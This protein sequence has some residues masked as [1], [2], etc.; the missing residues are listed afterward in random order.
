MMADFGFVGSSYTAP[1]IYQDDQE[2]INFYPEVDPIK[3]QGS[4]GVIAL[5]P[6]PGLVTKYTLLSAEVRGMRTLSG[7]N[8]LIVVS[9]N[10]VYS[11]NKSDVVTVIG[12][13]SSNTGY[14]SITD[15]QTTN[16]GLTAYIVDGSSRYT[17]IASTNTFSTIA[18]SDGPW[19]G[20][21][22]CGVMDNYIIYNEPNTQNFACTNLGVTT[23]SARY[24]T[25]DGSPDNLVSIIIDHRQIFLL[26]ENTSEV[27]VDVGNTINGLTTF[28]FGRVSGTSMQHGVAAAFSVA[29]FAE[30]FMFV[31]QDTRGQA[32]IGAVNGYSFQ[33]LST[34]AVEQTLI[35]INLSD[36][37]AYTYQI[38]GH[39]F[40]VV[41]FPSID[42][43]WVYDLVTQMWHK[44]LS[45]ESDSFHRHRSN[46]AAFFNGMN[47]VGD[48]QNGIVYQLQNNVYTDNG[49]TIKRVRRAP[50]LVADLQRQYFSELQIQFQPG[51]G[52]N[53]GQGSDPQ[54]MLKWSSDGGSTWSNEHWTSIGKIGH[55]K[56]RAIWRRLGWARDRIYEVM[57]TDPVK[58]VIVS[59]NLKGEGADN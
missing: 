55:Y 29:R 35:G 20:A 53:D 57:I 11:I 23:S 18:S 25:K 19:Q 56:N 45:W 31:S 49:N 17:W 33:R 6:T 12:T 4:R 15:N 42:L 41:T 26:G 27:W 2:C 48:Y 50:H 14:V 58:A 10:K 13:L 24:G 37:I 9:G 1:S 59:A 54:V 52:L 7:G 28:P 8:Y 39:E 43:T 51:V 34:H 21:S 46:C 3:P 22:V 32:I 47:L 30:Q 44:W 5:Y 36:A 38:E 40:Y 16:N